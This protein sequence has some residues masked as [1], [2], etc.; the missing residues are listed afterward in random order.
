MAAIDEIF[1][2][3]KEQGASDLHM[4]SGRPPMVRL[5]HELVAVDYD[6]LTP[7][8]NR[9][10]LYELLTPEQVTTFEKNREIDFGYELPGVT[11]LRCNIFDQKNGIA[12]VFRL[13]PTN[14]LTATQLG[15][16]ESILRFCQVPRGLVVVTGSTG[17]G[18]STTLAAMINHINETHSRHILTVEDPIE[19]VHPTR[20][21]LINQREVGSNT[22]S[23]ASALKSALRE[24]PDIILVGEMRDLETIQLAITAA[25][26]GH[27]VFGTLH[28]NSAAG[29]VDRI[30]DVFPTDQ[31]QQ[32]RVMLSESLKGVVAQRLLPKK[33]GKGRCA[34][35]EILVGTPAV[36]NLIREGKT[37]QLESMLQTGKRDGMISLDQSLMDLV[38]AGTLDAADAARHSKNPSQFLRQGTPVAAGSPRESLR[39]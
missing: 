15:L 17:S 20:K 27:L 8:L 35:F 34:A 23:F 26:T 19:F 33:G 18:K 3:I 9:K 5:G 22:R 29:T 21:S 38:Q 12:A 6:E 30:I 2:I 7:D 14:I 16:P 28:T 24:D 32:I 36:A 13:I 37:F 10:L 1:K 25:E 11:R 4:S 31:Q 39:H